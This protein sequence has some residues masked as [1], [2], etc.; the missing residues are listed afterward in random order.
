MRRWLAMRERCARCGVTKRTHPAP[1]PLALRLQMEGC[2]QYA[3]PAPR[4]ERWLIGLLSRR[5]PHG[6]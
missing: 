5:T 3:P 2:P 4:W 1:V 6:R